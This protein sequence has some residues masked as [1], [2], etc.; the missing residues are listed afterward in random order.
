MKHKLDAIAKSR[1]ESMCQEH[2]FLQ[3]GRSF[4]RLYSQNVLQV[5]MFRYERCF[6]HYSLDIGLM[7]IYSEPDPEFFSSSS[8]L[9]NYSICCLNNQ[10]TAVSMTEI[11][12]HVNLNITSPSDQLDI[13]NQKGFDWLDSI[14]SQ[15]KL[16]EALCYLDKAAYQGIVWN[17]MQKL[18]PYLSLGDYRSANMVISAI[19]DQHL[20]PKSFATPPWTSED[21]LRFSNTF[22]NKD[23][24][25]LQIYHWIQEK[26]EQS[27]KNYLVQN[28]TQNLK[29]GYFL[30]GHT[31]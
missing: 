14:S 11:D 13:L 30:R 12:G 28:R 20:G 16:L 21:Y 5:I 22:P 27:I 7:S 4:F 17:D 31:R 10:S 19:L 15:A 18:A 6:E 24:D 29:Y 25:L 3:R 1:L 23:K 9:P 26:N 8:A 2:S